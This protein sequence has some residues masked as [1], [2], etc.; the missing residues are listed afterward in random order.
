MA[1]L[2]V[3]VGTATGWALLDA[4]GRVLSGTE[5]LGAKRNSGA[6]MRYLNC[7]RWLDRMHAAHGLE[8]VAF[9][10]VRRHQGV[11]AAHVYGGLVGILT[12][13]CEEHSIPYTSVPVSAGKAAATG[14]GN[15]SKD[16]VL[17]GVQGWGFSPSFPDES[18]AIPILEARHGVD[19]MSAGAPFAKPS[20]RAAA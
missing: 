6:G 7:R 4:Q 20:R 5:D 11:A 10:E 12:G 9:E 13:W 16:A 8:E 19:T 3:D 17:V 2:A 14:K 15:A 1:A 18:D